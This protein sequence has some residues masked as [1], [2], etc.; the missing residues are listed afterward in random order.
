MLKIVSGDS[1]L[2]PRE[3]LILRAERVDD[4]QP[5]ARLLAGWKAAAV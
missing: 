2:E 4:T 5:E 3:K 1:S